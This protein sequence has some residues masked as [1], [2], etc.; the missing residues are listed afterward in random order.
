MVKCILL[1]HLQFGQGWAWKLPLDVKGGGQR[2]RGCNHLK[3]WWLMLIINRI[4]WFLSM[5]A[6]SGGPSSWANLGLLTSWC[7]LFLQGHP[8]STPNMRESQAE[9]ASFLWKV[10]QHQF[11]HSQLV[12]ALTQQ[13]M[14]KSRGRAV[15]Q[16][17]AWEW[18]YDCGHFWEIQCAT[19]QS[20][21][22]FLSL[23]TE[24]ILTMQGW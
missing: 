20:G 17:N 23:I 16:K 21:L 4:H 9:T 15:F 18:K 5:W 24:R 1:T 7:H 11:C 8:T 3:A 14:F 19:C 10:T 13:L 6:S 22:D 2:A 12:G